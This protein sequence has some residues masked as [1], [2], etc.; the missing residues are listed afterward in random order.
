M[1]QRDSEQERPDLATVLDHYGVGYKPDRVNQKILCPVHEERVPSCSVQL[2]KGLWMC[3]SCGKGGD[4]WTLIMVK[5]G[6]DFGGARAF[7]SSLGI[8]E[9][10]VGGGDE[11]V[12][13]SAYAPSH[14]LP[15]RSRNQEKHGGYVPAWKRG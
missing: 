11:Q 10:D 13:G 12:S 3:H 2:T 6:V 14:R 4:S 9:G 8:T 7:A 15:G 1:T 5:E